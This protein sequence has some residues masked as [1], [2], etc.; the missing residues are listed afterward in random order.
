MSQ[1]TFDMR[2]YNGE[3]QSMSIYELLEEYILACKQAQ[4]ENVPLINEC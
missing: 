4:K 1:V 2:N 3:K